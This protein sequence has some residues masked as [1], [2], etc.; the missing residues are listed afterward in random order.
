MLIVPSIMFLSLVRLILGMSHYIRTATVFYI[1]LN[2][3]N[4]LCI[5]MFAPWLK[6]ASQG[7][8]GPVFSVRQGMTQ[9]RLLIYIN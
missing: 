3:R 5:A 1:I 6:S 2:R 7:K 4:N 9:F 8:K